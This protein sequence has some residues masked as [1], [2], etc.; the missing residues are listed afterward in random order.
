MIAKIVKGKCFRGVV[1]Y[2]LDEKKGTEL[3]SSDGLR[4]KDTESIIQSF[5][6]QVELN[7]RITKPVYH[8]SLD[9]SA[10]DKAKLTN[11]LMVEIGKSYMEKMN[12]DET[13][14]LIARHYD[15]EHPH[16]HLI[17]NRVDFNGKTISDKNDRIKSERICKEITRQHQLYWAKGKEQVKTHRLK[18]AD[19]IK[20]EIYEALKQSIPECKDWKGLENQ[21]SE[22]GITIIYKYKGKTNE[23]QGVTFRKD[24][25]SFNGSKVDR[26]FSYSKINYQLYCNAHKVSHSNMEK[27]DYRTFNALKIGAELLHPDYVHSLHEQQQ[28]KFKYKKRRFGPKF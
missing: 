2:V 25:L 11:E 23:I 6:S 28:N 8:I 17:I 16:I 13:Q 10:N 4:L 24:E 26:L 7:Q 18:G 5:Q 3:L 1:N 9:F 20:Y 14:Y 19:K 15:K 12:I 21:L 22:K 27:L